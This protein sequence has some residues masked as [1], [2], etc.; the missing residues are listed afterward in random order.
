MP[1]GARVGL[2]GGFDFLTYNFL[3]FRSVFPLHE[4]QMLSMW[5]AAKGEGPEGRYPQG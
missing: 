3:F 4:R 1:F 5:I 2:F